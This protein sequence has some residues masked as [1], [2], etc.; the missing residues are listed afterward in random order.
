MKQ[1]PGT[2][3]HTVMVVTGKEE[4]RGGKYWTKWE[5]FGCRCPLLYCHTFAHL[6]RKRT[7]NGRLSADMQEYEEAYLLAFSETW[8]HHHFYYHDR[9]LGAF[10]SPVPPY[11]NK[12]E[13][14]K[15]QS[16]DGL[17]LCVKKRCCLAVIVC[18]TLCT[19]AWYWAINLTCST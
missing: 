10:G 9:T 3:V 18:E 2:L 19:R 5:V 15:R 12:I 11:R 8:L 17:C 13:T 1:C 6:G 7:S 16:V 14:G 4:N